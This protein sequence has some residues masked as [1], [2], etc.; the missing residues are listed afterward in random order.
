MNNKKYQWILYLIV[1]VI[2]CTISIQIYWN[3]KN[4]QTN[5]QQLINDVQVS[6]DNAVNEY[7]ANLAEQSTIALAFDAI[8][9][10]SLQ[11][12]FQI[13]DSIVNRFR[14]LNRDASEL[15]SFKI[16]IGDGKH[17][18][19]GHFTDS[20]FM[21]DALA[22]D[23]IRGINRLIFKDLNL[24]TADSVSVR[25]FRTLTSQVLISLSQDSLNLVK[26]DSILSNEL[27]RKNIAIDYDL[28][29]T[30]L[31]HDIQKTNNDIN[32][33][34]ETLSTV[35]KSSFLPN[36]SIL[37]INFTNETKV[38][39]KRILMGIL[40]ST[41]LV[42]AVISCLFYLLRIIKH[43]KDLAEVKND[44]ISNI[45]HEFKTPIATIGVALE[46]IKD[47]NILND[48]EKTRSYLDMSA[49][50]LRK[51]NLMVE[52]LLE[53]ATLETDNLILNTELVDLVNMLSNLIE[54]HS[55]GL[56]AK[57]L[58][59]N[60]E[61]ETLFAQVDAFHFENA[62]DNVI[63]NA[64]KYGGDQIKIHI[65]PK[66]KDIITIA[67]SDNGQSLKRSYKEKVFEKFY[68]IPK[69]NTHDIKGF[70]IGLYYSRSIIEKHGGQITLNLDNEGTHFKISIPK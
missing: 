38:I 48:P 23:S 68:R 17:T 27:L 24:S 57:T 62:L 61:D 37:K 5:K 20:V 19:Q 50:Q 4:Y 32:D 31:H 30:V 34:P 16:N 67:I 41:L 70:G 64:I 52:K 43:Q 18:L 53:T 2:L 11:R 49:L 36:D 28:T 14:V 63:D 40:I 15:D 54:K 56:D 44:L 42:L 21:Y 33:K 1:V 55:M 6:L 66:N 58:S 7:Y 22:L 45:T 3:Y 65:D 35:S 25:N 13:S 51:L 69:G 60:S 9:N 8:Q 47:F 46:S 39:L 10:D 29:F 59:F 26:V 12:H